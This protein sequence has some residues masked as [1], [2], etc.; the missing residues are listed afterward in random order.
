MPSF[1]IIS[2]V[3]TMFCSIVH[4]LY[5]M[6]V[7]LLYI[8]K[9]GCECTMCLT[10]QYTYLCPCNCLY[11]FYDKIHDDDDDDEIGFCTIR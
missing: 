1:L 11:L 6:C 8:T 2:N 10:V 3:L 5:F 9:G 7:F 4:F